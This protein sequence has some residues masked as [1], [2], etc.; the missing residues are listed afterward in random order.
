MNSLEKLI[1]E[2]NY[3]ATF[4]NNIYSFKDNCDD[5]IKFFKNKVKIPSSNIYSIAILRLLDINVNDVGIIFGCES[6]SLI[7]YA[8]NCCKM[9][10]VI[11]NEKNLINLNNILNNKDKIIFINKSSF[12]FKTLKGYF[13]FVI[14][15][16]SDNRHLNKYLYVNLLKKSKTLLSPSGK[17]LFAI[18]NIYNYTNF[19][20]IFLSLFYKNSLLSYTSYKN[21]IELGGFNNLITYKAFP[22][23]E[24]PHLISPFSNIIKNTSNYYFLKDNSFF[25]K[26][27][28][29]LKIYVDKILFNY[30]KLYSLSPSFISICENND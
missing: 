9:L 15:S 23:K 14:I 17:V 6:I 10:V 13:D 1:N 29:R 25:S 12:N 20:K 8:K 11:D 27:N 19:Y 22:H 16:L 7:N 4:K 3:S 18:N 2:L 21:I 5:D 30:L 26:L 24:H 28:R